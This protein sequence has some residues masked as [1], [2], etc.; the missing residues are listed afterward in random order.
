MDMGGG[1]G[2]SKVFGP[3]KLAVLLESGINP[4]STPS[5]TPFS[6]KNSSIHISYSACQPAS[7]EKQGTYYICNWSRE[8]A[9]AACN[10]KVQEGSLPSKALSGSHPQQNSGAPQPWWGAGDEAG[11]GLHNPS[12][13]QKSLVWEAGV[14]AWCS[15]SWAAC[16][17]ISLSS[18]PG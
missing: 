10:P 11:S 6:T 17:C 1:L 12:T 2:F 14:A 15:T 4:S 5:G 7:S 8:S 13:S 18:L 3:S 9:C 16:R